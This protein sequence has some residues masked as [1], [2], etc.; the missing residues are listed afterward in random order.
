[1]TDLLTT[2]EDVPRALTLLEGTENAKV[3]EVAARLKRDWR[4]IRQIEVDMAFG[5]VRVSFTDSRISHY[6]KKEMTAWVRNL[7]FLYDSKQQRYDV[8]TCVVRW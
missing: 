1:M 5:L 4:Y 6:F 7:D 2:Y 3:R 8:L